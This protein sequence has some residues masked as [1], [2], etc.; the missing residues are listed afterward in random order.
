MRHS[1]L[2]DC[3][4]GVQRSRCC[5]AAPT[6]PPEGAPIWHSLDHD[7]HVG[8]GGESI[9]PYCMCLLCINILAKISNHLELLK[10]NPKDPPEKFERDHA[11][12]KL[13]FGEDAHLM[14]SVDRVDNNYDRMAAATNCGKLL[15]L[16]KLL[17][18]WHRANDKVL[19]FSC[20]VRLLDILETFLVRRGY[21]KP[22]TLNPK[23]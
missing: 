10:P 7:T 18:L 21:H 15:A 23:P 9:C 11:V 17:A 1:E 4:S 14:G 13:A 22:L 12:A 20:S 6:G 16:E 2:C 3:G 8:R 5:Y 19:L